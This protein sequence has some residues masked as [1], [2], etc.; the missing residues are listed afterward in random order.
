MDSDSY[1]T[2]L[3]VMTPSPANLNGAHDGGTHPP[4][5]VPMVVSR[6]KVRRGRF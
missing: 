3:T 5:A 1:F 6:H 4:G 2:F